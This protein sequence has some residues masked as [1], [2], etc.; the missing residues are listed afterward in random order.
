MR[1]VDIATVLVRAVG[2][3]AL[4]FGSICLVLGII[5]LVLLSGPLKSYEAIAEGLIGQLAGWAVLNM[6]F[7]LCLLL[8]SRRLGRF[9]AKFSDDRMKQAAPS[10]R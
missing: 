9:C 2:T 8:P 3:V 7:G 1:L 5:A 10:E 4:V 6:L